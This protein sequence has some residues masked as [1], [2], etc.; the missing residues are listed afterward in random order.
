MRALCILL[1]LCPVLPF[2][3]SAQGAEPGASAL[4]HAETAYRMGEWE[5]AEQ[6]ALEAGGATGY[7]LAAEAVLAE[8]MTWQEGLDRHTAARTA[9]DHTQA[10]LERDDQLAEAH[11]RMAAALGFRGRF[12]PTWRAF[13]SG[14]PQ[15][16]REHIRTALEL[17]PDNPWAHALL[18]AWHMEVARRGGDGTLGAD[19]EAGLERY[20]SAARMAPDEPGIAYHLAV[21]QLAAD[22]QRFEQDAA[23]WLDQAIAAEVSEAFDRAMQDQAR[24]LAGLLAEDLQAAHEDAV[25][26]L[27]N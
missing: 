3:G 5:R 11:L 8:L 20:R 13:M 7:T 4:E 19:M 23:G 2:A 1:L 27:E 17:E 9:Q 12:I 25:Y 10:A 26:R 24:A 22:P 16:G 18:G 6:L 14:I 15:E 21:A